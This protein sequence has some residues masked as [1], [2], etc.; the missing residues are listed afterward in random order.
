M[1]NKYDELDPETWHAASLAVIL[2]LLVKY[3]GF[4][5]VRME[6]TEHSCESSVWFR[7]FYTFEGNNYMSDGSRVDIVK[8]RLIGRVRRLI[9]S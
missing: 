3:H 4:S 8:K 5:Q 9:N 2:A 1:A 7:I 6:V